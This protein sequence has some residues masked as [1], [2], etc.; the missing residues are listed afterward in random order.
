M[1]AF[2]R[3]GLYGWA[4]EILWTGFHS[5]LRKD[6]TLTGRSSLWMFPIY[7]SAALIGPI[8]RHISSLPVMARGV[9]YMCGIFA[10]EYLTGS[11]L[12]LFHLCP[13]DYS[14]AP[15]NIHGIIRLDYAPVWFCAGL[16]FEWLLRRS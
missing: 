11:L 15:L 14:H 8:Y 4:M 2:F 16:I 12:N 10:V 5:I 6:P 3:C 1:I 13:W 7:G 9:I